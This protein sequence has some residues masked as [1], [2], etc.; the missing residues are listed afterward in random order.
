VPFLPSRRI[1][2]LGLALAGAVLAMGSAAAEPLKV[3][4]FVAAM[5][6][7]GKNTGDRAG[8]FQHWYERY[9]MDSPPMPVKGALNPVYCNADGVCGA[10][11]G[12]GKVASSSSMQ[13]ILL[14]PQFDFSQAYYILSGVGGVPPSRGTIAEVVWATWL[15]D[16]DLGHRWAADEVKPGEPLFM[17]RKGYESS[18]SII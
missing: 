1:V 16:Y 18:A 12:M 17:P 3:K 11:L 9:W 5:F 10:V 6:E 4:V 7:I 2:G 15:V 8:E 13:A 14:N